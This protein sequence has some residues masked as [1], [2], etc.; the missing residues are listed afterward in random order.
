MSKVKFT[1]RTYCLCIG[2]SK[3]CSCLAHNF[4]VASASGMVQYRDPVSRPFV[5]HIKA[6][7]YSRN[8]AGASM[9][10]GHICF[11]FLFIIL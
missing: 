10:Y 3:T 8:M 9:F 7:S 2:F 1:V 6:L 11:L 4:V 5:R